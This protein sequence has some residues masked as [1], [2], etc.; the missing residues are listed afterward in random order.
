MIIDLWLRSES[1]DECHVCGEPTL[2]AGIPIADGRVI[3]NDWPGRCDGGVPACDGCRQVQARLDWPLD[4]DAFHHVV[5]RLR[6]V[7]QW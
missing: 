3:P 4:I 7:Q 6:K 5:M 2:R 1:S